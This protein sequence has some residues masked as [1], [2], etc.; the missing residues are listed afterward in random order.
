M[1]L[2][3]LIFYS[4]DREDVP[5]LHGKVSVRRLSKEEEEIAAVVGT[6]SPMTKNSYMGGETGTSGKDTDST[7]GSASYHGKPTNQFT[8]STGTL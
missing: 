1:T 4:Y 7:V 3:D 2:R 5:N 6:P 8:D